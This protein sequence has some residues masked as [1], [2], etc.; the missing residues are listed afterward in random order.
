MVRKLHIYEDYNDDMNAYNQAKAEYDVQM[1]DYKRAYADWEY[2]T[3]P[4]V[5]L[6]IHN[7]IRR[8][9]MD[10]VVD[11]NNIDY[12]DVYFN[13]G[14][15]NFTNRRTSVEY[16]IDIENYNQYGKD[17]V[18]TVLDELQQALQDYL[19]EIDAVTNI[20]T[21]MEED[22]R[23]VRLTISYNL[24]VP[25]NAITKPTKPT[26]PIRPVK[27]A[28]PDKPAKVGPV[29]GVYTT[30]KNSF[31]CDT[32]EDIE[33]LFQ[34]LNMDYDT[35]MNT[36]RQAGWLK[37]SKIYIPRETQFAL[38]GSDSYYDYVEILNGPLT[39]CRLPF[40]RYGDNTSIDYLISRYTY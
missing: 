1:K 34:S 28:K 18:Y 14:R 15:G 16:R 29:D 33:E 21:S 36:L 2:N 26:K 22:N 11:K 38:D 40:N 9:I 8:M 35:I 24:D 3:A 13:G 32:A 25:K 7:T 30:N 19:D 23:I 17:Y 5:S 12:Q 6:R 37:G 27:P 39:G 20:Y 10:I 4:K 31:Y